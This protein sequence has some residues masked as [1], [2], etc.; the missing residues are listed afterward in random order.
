MNDAELLAIIAQAK[1]EKATVLDLSNKGIKTVPSEISQLTYLK[2]LFL[3]NNQIT[4]FPEVIT[5]L[6]SLEDLSL[7]NNQ[8][9]EIPDAIS[10]LVNLKELSLWGNKISKISEA[11][12]QLTN[13]EDIDLSW[14]K[15]TL[16]PHAIT[17][18]SSLK[19]LHLGNNKIHE[20]PCEISQLVNLRL[21]YL[22]SNEIHEIPTSIANITNLQV[23]SL[24]DNK[25]RKIP[26]EVCQILN[27]EYLSLFSNQ[28]LE[29]PKEIAKLTNLIQ[30]DLNNNQITQIPD[31][32]AKLTN[33]IHLN[34][35]NNQI[36]HIPDAIAKLTNL[37]IL[38]LDRNQI[39]QIPDSI[40]TLTNLTTL[41]FAGN[42][43][44]HI[45]ELVSNLSNLSRFSLCNN[46]ITQIPESISTLINLTGLDFSSNEITQIPESLFNL[47]NLKELSIWGNQITQIPESISKLT[48]LIGL[49]LSRN[50]II[51][52][53]EAITGL[54]SLIKL[55]FSHNQITEIPE[56]ISAL[57]N[58]TELYL[59]SNQIK[60][61]PE[62]ITNLT[63]LTTLELKDNPLPIPP[64][65][66]EDANNPRA[67]I[68]YWQKLKQGE[69]KPLNEA[70]VILI[71]H[72]A[73]GKT[74]LVRQLIDRYFK[75]DE[76]KTE[77]IDIRAWQI[78][79]REETV[80]LRVWDFGGQEIMHATHQF[81]LTERS[82][83][84]LVLN[85]RK[86]EGNNDVEYWLK[87]IESFGKD[88]PVL[89]IANKSD[90]HP[91]KLNRRHLLEKYPNIQGFFE[92]SCK[93]GLGVDE[94]RKAI[95]QQIAAMDHVFNELP[96]QWFRL[97]E[98]IEQD[99]RDHISY[100]E[101]E[102]ICKDQEIS[103]RQE[104][105]DLIRLLHLL[106]IVLNFADDTR[107]QDTSVLNPEWV[108]G[109]VYRI[110]NDNLLSTKHKGMLNW[111][112][113]TRIL[114]PKNQG[115]RDCY[116]ENRDRQFILDMMQKFELCFPLEANSQKPIYLIP[117]LL[118]E[119][120]PD[121]GTWENTL[122][123]EY[124]YKI[125]FS[126]VISRFIVKMHHRISKRTYWRTGVI[127][128]FPEGNR[129]YIKADLAD[130]KIFIRIDGNPNTRRSSL[131]A[132]R[133]TFE[134]IHHSI[135]ALEV[136]ERVPLADNPKVSI[137]Y[138]HLLKLESRGETNYFPEGSDRAYNIREL[139]DGISSIED[140]RSRQNPSQR[141]DE[142]NRYLHP[143][144]V[145]IN[146]H[147]QQQQIAN[148]SQESRYI[149]NLQGA[150]I[151]NF[152]NEVKDK[153]TQQASNFTQTSGA[154]VAELLQILN[155]LRQTA[156]QFPPD[157]RE[158]ITIDIDDVE[159]EIQKPEK[160]R[161]LPK[162]KKRLLA[163]LAAVS[164][165]AAPIA[166]ITDFTNNV[167]EIGNK[168]HIELPFTP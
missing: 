153:A 81:F 39:K 133:N 121:T 104:R 51:K 45:S 107:L 99:N 34:L 97:K 117:E 79:A 70:K 114:T 28:I 135:S 83:Y 112:D 69:R 7:S 116:Q 92:T 94:L 131:A 127:L 91:L 95:A 54:T 72:G 113:L 77:G 90:E 84:L 160:E 167:L 157:I 168:L 55:Y 148:M 103:D 10:Q 65:I 159:A 15:L 132:I 56:A 128:A 35:S 6:F 140:R 31:E 102:C 162:L 68:G 118:D 122:N 44:T 151:A 109:G 150:N 63:N 120:E 89:I 42:K 129:A 108:T 71:G 21:L 32:I 138:K 82:L 33:L 158:D 136:D 98:Q 100:T 73:V 74:S 142:F 43:I 154:S 40:F 13:L 101:Y 47:I 155:T 57:T 25:I 30:L 149:N 49:D 19:R 46:K 24:Y 134:S 17:Q 29:I 36:T 156:T 119:E 123:L 110:L 161:S 14:A 22:Y 4:E 166:G 80:K 12:A 111:Q 145:T 164:V 16:I 60:E 9:C 125:L 11:I 8:I 75:P 147:N 87:I 18:I 66:L 163:L 53:P 143:V 50:Q 3:A 62:S 23:L 130:A 139:L 64:E 76:T 48:N 37:N 105:R 26:E 152:A 59:F 141:E 86:D 146:N 78:T 67:I 52:I 144:N 88:A 85:A 137:S 93:T 41:Y 58:L 61:I 165:I 38:Y 5:K 124:H 126:S 20:I 1:R 2:R 27:L 115:D 96:Q 106:G